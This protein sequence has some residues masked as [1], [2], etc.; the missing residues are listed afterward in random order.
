[1]TSFTTVTRKAPLIFGIFFIVLSICCC[2]LVVYYL[3]KPLWNYVSA[4]RICCSGC[5]SLSLSLSV[6]LNMKKTLICR[7][8]M[9]IFFG[10]VWKFNLVLWS[11]IV[12]KSLCKFSF[13]KTIIYMYKKIV[14]KR[15]KRISYRN[16]N[17]NQAS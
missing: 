7:F 13:V 8:H 16:I 6:W 11:Y 1:M 10:A 17:I 4:S 14:N 15:G 5:C 3:T 9:I 12:E 2:H